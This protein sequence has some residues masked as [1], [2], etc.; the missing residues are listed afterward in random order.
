[1]GYTLPRTW[2]VGELVTKSMLDEQIRDNISYLYLTMNTKT[3]VWRVIPELVPVTV[4]DDKARIPIPSELNGFELIRIH[5][6]IDGLSTS[7]VVTVQLY[8]ITQAVDIL[9]TP[10]TIDEGEDSSYTAAIQPVIA[11]ANRLVATDNRIRC[12]VDTGGTGTKGLVVFMT[13]RIVI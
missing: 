1:M 12:D 9:S 6:T 7:G 13:Y 11:S 4:G 8:N 10:I 5:A 3:L 2:V